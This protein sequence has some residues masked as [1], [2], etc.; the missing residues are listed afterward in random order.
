MVNRTGGVR[1]ILALD[2]GREM[3]RLVWRGVI[4]AWAASANP[5]YTE[6]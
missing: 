5:N 1:G 3:E 6:I 2:K 4:M